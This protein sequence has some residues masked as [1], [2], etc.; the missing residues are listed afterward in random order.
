[1][2]YEDLAAGFFPVVAAGAIGLF[3]TGAGRK[4]AVGVGALTIGG[5]GFLSKIATGDCKPRVKKAG[6]KGYAKSYSGIA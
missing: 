1:M 4:G 6:Q 2:V 3:P 5:S